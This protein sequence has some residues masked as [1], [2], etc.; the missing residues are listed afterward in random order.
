MHPSRLIQPF[1]PALAVLLLVGACDVEPLPDEPATDDESF[2]ADPAIRPEASGTEGAVV[3]G[4]P[5]AS[6][7]GERVLQE[8]GTAADAVVT[9]AAVLAV[10]RPHM[11]NVG[12]DAF[13]LFHDAG[14]GEVTALNGSGRAPEGLSPETVTEAADDDDESEDMPT[15]GAL[16][17]TVPGMV[18]AWEQAL[19]DHGTLSL[20]E[21]LEPAIA[22]AEDGFV[23]TEPLADDL[24][25]ATEDLNEAG[26]DV[27][28][29][30]G[31]PL[32]PGDVLESPALAGTLQLLAEEGA[33][34]L[35]GGELAEHL[36]AFLQEE[37]SPM[38]VSDFQAHEADWWDPVTVE[39]RDHQVHSMPPNSQGLTFLQMLGMAEHLPLEE[40]EGPYD[41]DLVHAL[42]EAKKLAFADRAEWVADPDEDLPVDDLL[43][44]EY[45]ADRAGE[46]GEDAADEVESGLGEA[47]VED[48]GSGAGG[49]DDTVYLMAVDPDGNAVSWI[50]SI[51]HSLGSRLMEPET[52]I[53]LQNRGAGFT[54]EEGHPNELEPGKRPFHTLL[55]GMV[56][57]PD[58]E[59]VMALGSPGGDG[60]PQSSTQVL[61]QTLVFGLSA[62]QAVEAARFRSYDG[63]ELEVEG[64]MPEATRSHLS[65]RGHDVTTVDGWTAPF[66]NQMI[67]WRQGDVLRTG[68]DMRREGS[69]RAF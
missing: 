44:R 31:E 68:A 29:P 49:N 55:P 28:R 23:V 15:H 50:Q 40:H 58:G 20:A 61:V 57:D 33:S 42:V 6:A 9:M 19:E 41:P 56:T 11:N 21:A 22:L 4:H 59:F 53:I 26:Q 37:G 63:L 39:F 35:Y 43:D 17:V 46:I 24:H 65:E 62:Q 30:G 48:A 47:V 1:V 25:D 69:A 54:L 64:R 45:L 14:S 60:Q 13:G 38:E 5:L 16:S 8:G 36:S 27:Y 18:S 12:G 10:V 51:F 32:A 67:I 7:A 2:E 3:S 34:A 52:G 66:G